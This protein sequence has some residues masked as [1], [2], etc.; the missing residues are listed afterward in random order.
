MGAGGGGRVKGKG[1]LLGRPLS[2]ESLVTVC[3]VCKPNEGYLSFL[4]RSGLS[5]HVKGFVIHI[6]RL[7]KKNRRRKRKYIDEEKRNELNVFF[8]SL[9]KTPV[10][11]NRNLV[12]IH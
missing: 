12:Y 9:H 6:L 8:F 5:L 2:S 7:E 3:S 11:L 4:Y 1:V 10:Y